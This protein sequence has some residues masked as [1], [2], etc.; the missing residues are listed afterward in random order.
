MQKCD[1]EA[2]PWKLSQ[3]PRGVYCALPQVAGA[4]TSDTLPSGFAHQHPYA[5]IL[6]NDRS[7]SYESPSNKANPH[8]HERKKLNVVQ[9]SS[10][11]MNHTG[12]W[13]SNGGW[14]RDGRAR[15]IGAA[16]IAGSGSVWRERRRL[17]KFSNSFRW[18][19]FAPL[20]RSTFA[21]RRVRFLSCLPPHGPCLQMSQFSTSVPSISNLW[22][23]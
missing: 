11:C 18:T 8:T 13:R 7:L 14:R 22:L 17:S 21:S 3:H 16:F 5:S 9:R 23:S 15:N 12:P 20:P 6:P 2:W 19:W 4:H 10:C 1:L